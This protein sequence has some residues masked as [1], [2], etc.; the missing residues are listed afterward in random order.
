[1]RKLMFAEKG[2]KDRLIFEACKNTG[3]NGVTV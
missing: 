2:T 1:M 3:E